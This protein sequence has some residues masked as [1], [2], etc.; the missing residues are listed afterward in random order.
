MTHIKDFFA[1]ILDSHKNI[2]LSNKRKLVLTT[3]ASILLVSALIG[4]VVGIKSRN[5]TTESIT[6]SAAHA[7][8]KSSCSSTLYPELCYS[9]ITSHPDMTKKVK[10]QKD[11]I[12]LAV[13]I[14]TTAVEHSYFQIKKLTTRKGLTHRQITALHDCME[15]VSETLDELHEVI[16]DLEEYQ[17][18][19]SLRQHADD[20]KTLMSSAI[21][22]QETCLDGFSHD[23]ADKK[24][25]KS[26]EKSEERVE[27][28]CSNALAMICN[29]TSTDL[30]NER[31]LNGRNLNEEH[32]NVWPEWLSTGDRRLLQSGTVRPNVIVAADGGGNYK[33]VAA[34]VAAAP[35]KSKTRYVIRIKAGVYRENVDVPKSKTNIMFM[36]DGRKNTIITGSRSVKGGTT[37]FNSATVAVVGTGFLARDITFQNTAGASNH[38]AVAL[39]V[40][41]D[42]SAFY[43]CDMLGYQD[44]LYVH[45]NRQFYINCFIAGT[46]DFIFGNAAAVLQNCDIHAR[47]P[48]PGQKNMLT[49]QGR[50][51]PN[52]NTG[53]VIQKSRIGATSDL[54]PVQGSFPTYLGRP[55]KL[56][57]R[58]VVM[59][60]TV[61]NVIHPAGWFEWDGNFALDT[62]T[63]REYQNTGAGAGT[64]NRVKWKG[65]RVITSSSEAQGF[66]PGNFIAGGSWLSST[67]FPFSL[68]L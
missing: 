15:M 13:N 22:N 56:Y 36:G 61:S 53:I 9:T 49:A 43:Q 10:S 17:T 37:T 67:S 60:S 35:S 21:T 57:A 38:Q 64:S 29:M 12:E 44:T 59:Q 50:T 23:S 27:K 52:Q 3:F 16:K 63:Y 42:F 4:I 18:K 66:T 51:D 34:A 47:R 25:R 54:Q 46:V 45:S 39:R 62:L 6:V 5:S 58:T 11:V 48:G 26:L 32:N 24:V 1:G 55:W 30:A 20:L 28:M 65:F 31:K 8:V 68:S 7:V 33:T 41:S 40:G 14:T 19:R 2:N